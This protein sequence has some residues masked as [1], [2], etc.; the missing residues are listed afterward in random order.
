[1][2]GYTTEEESELQELDFDDN[3]KVIRLTAF[4]NEWRS[5][6]GDASKKPAA[7][8]ILT[9]EPDWIYE[10]IQGHVGEVYQEKLKKAAGKEYLD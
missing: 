9:V 1:L 3:R 4:R 6:L 8:R 5:K 2:D 7:A 10:Q